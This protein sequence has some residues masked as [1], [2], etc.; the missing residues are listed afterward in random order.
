MSGSFLGLACGLVTILL[1]L[2]QWWLGN[3]RARQQK[4]EEL[5]KEAKDALASN[6]NSRIAALFD[7][8]R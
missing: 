5:K 4:T 2:L 3:K 8:L 1:L 6:S 7:K